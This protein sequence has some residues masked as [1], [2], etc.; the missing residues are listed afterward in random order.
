MQTPLNRSPRFEEQVRIPADDFQLAGMLY[1]LEGEG[2]GEG[3]VVCPPFGDERKSAWRVLTHMARTLSAAGYP[4]VQFD[5]WGCGESAGDFLDASVS[6]RLRD[7]SAA[8]D[9]LRQVADIE[10]LCLLGLRLG[11]T[12]ATRV[13][14]E[15]NDCTSM[16][17]IEPIV[18][19][20]KYFDRM[21][22]RKKLRQMITAGR[23]EGG[24]DGSDIV[25]LDGYA[26]RRATLEELQQLTFHTPDGE[27]QENTLL[28]QV[29]FNESLRSNTEEAVELLRDQAGAQPMV[30]KLV[31]PPFWSR[32]DVTD[33]SRLD[34]VVVEF[35][36][37][38]G[39]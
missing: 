7:I 27:C 12:L 9:Y 36:T 2:S 1:G 22:Q 14:T 35:M 17:L 16:V 23:A 25:D 15:R 6:T 11:A 13:A 30:K 34:E 18:S 3:V 28:V 5:Y 19:V 24:E 10:N 32:V 4:V 39:A 29:S 38:D 8:A 26:V 31:M 33:T 37:G 20:S 21:M